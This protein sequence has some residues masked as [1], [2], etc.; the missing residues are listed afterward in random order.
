MK[1]V[2][3]TLFVCLIVGSTSCSKVE[4][5]GG[6]ATL[7]GSVLGQKYN[8]IGAIVAEYPLAK[9]DIFI[10]YG[11]NTTYFD[12]KIETSYDG[13]FE[14]SKLQPGSYTIFC[15]SKAPSDPSGKLAVLKT[16]TISKAEKKEAIDVGL[17]TLRD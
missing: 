11:A 8:A 9:Q 4:G 16:V 12:D 10:V 3:Y 5:R 15:Y 17:F 7:K 2:F 14:F 1:F 6:G 13:T